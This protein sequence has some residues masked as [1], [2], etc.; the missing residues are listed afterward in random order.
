MSAYPSFMPPPIL[1]ISDP[2]CHAMAKQVQSSI[3]AQTKV[4]DTPTITPTCPPSPSLPFAGADLQMRRV[5][6]NM[7]GQSFT[8]LRTAVVGPTG[9]ELDAAGVAPDAPVLLLLHSFDSSSLEWRRLYPLLQ[10]RAGL[11]VV[12]VDLL[13]W[14]FTD[15]AAWQRHPR[16]PVTPAL[17]CDHLE[18]F[19]QQH[20]GGRPLAVQRLVL[21]SAQGF[22]EGV[23]PAPWPLA[24]LGVALLRTVW[25]RSRANQVPGAAAAV[26]V[27]PLAYH[28][29][30]TWATDDAWRVGR[31]NTF[32]PGWFEAN[33][34]FIQSGGYFMPEQ[35]IQQI[36]QPVLLLWGRHDEIIEPKLAERWASALGPQ[37]CRLC[38]VERAGHSP[39]IEQAEMVAE[40]IIEFLACRHEGQEAG[41]V[42]HE[43]GAPASIPMSK[44][45]LPIE[46]MKEI[47][48][49][50]AKSFFAQPENA[51]A[52]GRLQQLD[53]LMDEVRQKGLLGDHSAHGAHAAKVVTV[54]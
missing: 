21:I 49:P 2:Y 14:G 34:A 45:A 29:K 47:L 33:V 32:L 23:P 30:A 1:D 26:A 36:Q 19:R 7:P 41:A 48:R 31:L 12:A 24:A 39:Q 46:S 43:D 42:R 38:W 11:P 17:K 28:D 18:A 50:L 8:P 10:Q 51:A 52:M 35:R 4:Y 20:L 40:H 25:L 9:P 3:P 16:L 6:V 27:R 54:F 53:R 15:H 5:P 22:T 13:G 37:R 44:A